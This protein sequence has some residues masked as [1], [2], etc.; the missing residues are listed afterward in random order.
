MSFGINS[1]MHPAR[2]SSKSKMEVMYVVR[3]VYRIDDMF[4]PVAKIEFILTQRPSA[5]MVAML[6]LFFL[7][8]IIR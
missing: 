2:G 5:S 1:L 8:Q 3:M 4:V 6:G 7:K